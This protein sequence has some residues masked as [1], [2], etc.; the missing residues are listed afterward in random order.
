MIETLNSKNN[1]ALSARGLIKFLKQ[2]YY[3]VILVAI[4]IFSFALD[5][6]VLTRYSLSYGI[7]GAFYDIQV[8]N[9]LQY[10]FPL[11]NDPP[12]AY[13][14]L[15]P[16]VILSGKSFLGVK[17]GMAFI[18]SFLTI[19][20][21][22]LTEFYTKTKNGG[23]IGSKIPA[24]LSAFMVTVNVNYFAMIGNYM[25]N[26]V[27]VLFLSVFIYFAICWFEDIKQWKRYG[28]LTLLLLCVNLLTHIY[29]GALAIVLF[30]ALLSFSIMVKVIKT[31]KLPIYD[32][33][34][35][36]LS[37]FLVLGCLVVLFLV[38]PVMYTKY[39]TVMSFFNSSA[40]VTESGSMSNPLSGIIFCSLPYILGIAASVII[41]CRGL[42]E[43]IVDKDSLIIPKNNL[44]AW[45]YISLTII[46]LILTSITSSQYQS[47][48]LLM[49]FL[50]IALVVPLGLKFMETEFMTKYPSK[51]KVTTILV[52]SI[53]MIFAFSS[54]H[55]ASESFKNLGPTITTDEYNE[56]IKMKKS[57]ANSTDENIIILAADF[58]TTYWVE[59][60]LGDL[61][62]NN[63][64]N[65]TENVQGLQ[66]NY[67][68]FTIYSVS[69]QDNET[70]SS[71]GSA[72][73]SKTSQS[74]Q[75]DTTVNN[76]RWPG[77]DTNTNYDASFLLP[78]GPSILPNNLDMIFNIGEKFQNGQ[79]QI[80]RGNKPPG[81]TTNSSNGP[82]GNMTHLNNGPPGNM[83][84]NMNMQPPVNM[85]NSTNMTQRV[86][87]NNMASSADGRAMNLL[88][89]F[90]NS[91]TTIYSGKYFKIVKITV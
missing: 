66:D 46:L 86:P 6:F 15:T 59:Y 32:T 8:R 91:G 44:L 35:F 29:T 68:N 1:I 7:D 12:L 27:G 33:K 13:Y 45:I 24:L 20:A 57:F 23:N 85:I 76:G 62:N 65:V 74:K 21:F 78:Y 37:G 28:V 36:G 22:L 70:S 72:Q 75:N 19:P 58:E 3:L 48:F 54:Y 61:G 73:F 14:L 63:K 2:R 55:T 83:T 88:E 84:N 77:S 60:V 41:L 49:A 82:S 40:A 56:L 69:S 38:Y 47:R 42:K 89:S 34:I 25:Q 87:G 79:N 53:A 39:G 67:Q 26:L 43:K 18:G 5:M 90:T 31:H 51:K 30:F 10:G 80:L 52:I 17:I 64:V 11:S 4:F 9:I 50:P 16:F 71:P 81:N